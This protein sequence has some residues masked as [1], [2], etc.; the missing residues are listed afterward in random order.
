MILSSARQITRMPSRNR[1]A[2]AITLKEFFPSRHLRVCT[3][4]NFEPSAVLSFCHVTAK[5]VL[6]NNALQIQFT[7]PEITQSQNHLH[8]PHI[9][10][11]MGERSLPA[12]AEVLAYD[13]AIAQFANP[14][15]HKS[16][17]RMQRSTAGSHGGI[18]DF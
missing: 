13:P 9:A 10:T 4:T 15:H 3:I 2:V 12:A 6:C 11:E 7:D 5:F 1:L 17:N 18:A 8:A 16:T 14:F